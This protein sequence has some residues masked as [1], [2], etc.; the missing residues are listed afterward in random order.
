MKRLSILLVLLIT[1]CATLN[2]LNQNMEHS[3]E[4]LSE[5]TARMEKASAAIEENTAEIKRSTDSLQKTQRALPFAAI[6]FL[7]ILLIPTLAL[8]KIYRFR[9]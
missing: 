8:F 5:N 9:K 4:L 3:S 1:G 6:F 2:Q 7:L